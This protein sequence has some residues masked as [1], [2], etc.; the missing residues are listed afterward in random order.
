MER[1][2]YCLG[3]YQYLDEEESK[4]FDQASAGDLSKEAANKLILILLTKI[5]NMSRYAHMNSK[6]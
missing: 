2:K 6:Y 4:L 1:D 5:S 3:K